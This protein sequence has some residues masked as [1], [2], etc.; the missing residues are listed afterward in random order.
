MPFLLELSFERL[1]PSTTYF[2]TVSRLSARRVFY[3]HR[4]TYT[5][6]NTNTPWKLLL[7]PE[8][9]IRILLFNIETP[10]FALC[11]VISRLQST[12]WILRWGAVVHT[13]TLNWFLS[14]PITKFTVLEP[15]NHSPTQFGSG[16]DHWPDIRQV[17]DAVP[18]S[19]K[20]V[21]QE[22][23]TEFP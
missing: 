4:W 8:G 6:L 17:A 13:F 14:E 11:N 5:Q 20:P 21:L 22:Y 12:D 15:T 3:Q 2:R 19:V 23:R 1:K 9:S 18:D 16:L 10:P 7:H